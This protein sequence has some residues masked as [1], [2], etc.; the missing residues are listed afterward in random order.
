MRPLL[1]VDQVTAGYG[2]IRVLR[3][4][5]F[6]VPEGA[7]VALVGSNGVGKTTTLRVLSGLLRPEQ[8]TVRLDG[9]PIDG[10]SPEEISRL[11]LTLIPE[12]RGIFPG[13]TVGEI[14]EVWGRLLSSEDRQRRLEQV[15]GLFPVL[16]DRRG[17]RAGTLSGGEQQM[18]ALS[19]AFLTPARVILLD[20]VSMG[21]APRVV[22]QL[23]AAIEVLRDEGMSMV[24]VEQFLTYVLEHAD[25]CLS[26]AK[27]RVEAVG[28]PWE[29][30]ADER[31]LV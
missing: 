20:E 31:S 25:F 26:M 10:R 2:R 5:S 27:G 9:V 12:G 1:E 16:A 3:D 17:Q 29:F 28:E 11:G 19:R 15:Y 22:G 30:A 6:V 14:L 7:V 4:L 18:L 13:L 8:G 23:F 24:I 21:L